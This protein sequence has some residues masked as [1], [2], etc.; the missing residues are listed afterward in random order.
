MSST[1]K[2]ILP[3]QLGSLFGRLCDY[4]KFFPRLRNCLQNLFLKPK[5]ESESAMSRGN[6][7]AYCYERYNQISKYTNCFSFRFERTLPASFPSKSLNYIVI[8]SYSHS[9]SSLTIAKIITSPGTDIMT[10]VKNMIAISICSTFKPDCRPDRSKF[11][12][13]GIVHCP[14]KTCSGNSACPKK[15][16]ISH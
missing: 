6:L 12:L 15:V 8:T 16:S 5:I 11:E 3:K 4:L 10:T 7:F 14:N 13:T 2:W 9:L 1:E